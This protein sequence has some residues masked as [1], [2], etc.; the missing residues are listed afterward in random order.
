[1]F[2]KLSDVEKIYYSYYYDQDEFLKNYEGGVFRGGFSMSYPVATAFTFTF[3]VACWYLFQRILD[4]S[5]K[6]EK[7]IE[8]TFGLPILGSI[9]HSSYKNSLD[10]RLDKGEK[11]GLVP[12]NTEEYLKSVLAACNADSIA[13]VY[14]MNDP[15]EKALADALSKDLP[16]VKPAGNLLSDSAAVEVV[17]RC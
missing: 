9:D 16:K 1:M 12:A 11:F 10:K 7:E 4:K 3:L 13:L 5:I 2:Q 15:A 17:K 14:D 6:N 8:R